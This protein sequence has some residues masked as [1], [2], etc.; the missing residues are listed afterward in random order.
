MTHAIDSLPILILDVFSRCNCRCVMC[1]IWKR[2]VPRHF[3]TRDLARQ[4]E[5][6]DRLRVEWVVLTG[7]EPLM[8]PDLFQLCAPLKQRGI[9]LTLLTT[10]LLLDRFAGDIVRYVDEIIVSLDGPPEIHDRIRRV[11]GAFERLAAG[12]R[13]VRNLR[14]E[15]PVSARSTIQRLNCAHLARTVAAARSLRCDSISFLAA[16]AHSSAFDHDPSSPEQSFEMSASDLDLLAAEIERLIASG[17]CGGFIAESPAKL[18]RLVDQGRCALGIGE[19][20]APSCNAPWVSAVV[21]AD[22]AVRPCFFHPPIGSVAS[23]ASLHEVLNGP[24]ALTFRSELDTSRNPICRRCVCSLNW[25][26]SRS[27]A[28]LVS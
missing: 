16:D 23:G 4:L 1:D 9:R 19:P 6:I 18:R 8:H 27:S 22:G 2:T 13:S 5:A 11:P 20:A 7:G 3:D 25:K 26:Q 14:S 12:I 28:P 24:A 21:S 17:D 15:F 10:G